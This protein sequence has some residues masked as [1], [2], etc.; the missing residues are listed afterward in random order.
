VRISGTDVSV[1]AAHI[2]PGNDESPSHR[3]GRISPSLRSPNRDEQ[4][5]RHYFR[6]GGRNYACRRPLPHR[7]RA[8]RTRFR[9]R[10]MSFRFPPPFLGRF[11]RRDRFGNALPGVSK[12]ADASRGSGAIKTS[13][14]R[15]MNSLRLSRLVYRAL[16]HARRQEGQGVA[17]GAG[18][19]Q[20]PEGPT[21][22]ESNRTDY[23]LR[24]PLAGFRGCMPLPNTSCFLK[25][26]IVQG[27]RPLA[28]IRRRPAPVSAKRP[29][30]SS[31]CIRW[32]WMAFPRSTIAM[33]S[34]T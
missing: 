10:A 30:A 23:S 27:A 12:S 25:D 11:R 2:F 1:G 15:H 17:G 31:Q 8:T 19:T 3:V 26:R 21:A 18:L 33:G 6:S 7:A 22:L 24:L 20:L 4:N 32:A 13:P 34:W 5:R 14:L 9:R 28:L 29:R 16:R